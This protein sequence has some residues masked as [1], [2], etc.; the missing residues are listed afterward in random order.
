LKLYPNPTKNELF[1][2][3][4]NLTNTKLDVLDINGKI[5]FNQALNSTNTIDTSKL[6]NDIYLF[7]ITSDEGSIIEKII[8]N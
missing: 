2:N 1:I 4:K 6:S 3:A 5:L 8:K 7:K